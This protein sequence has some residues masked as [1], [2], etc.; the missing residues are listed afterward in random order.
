MRSRRSQTSHRAIQRAQAGASREASLE[1]LSGT[2]LEEPEEKMNLL[3]KYAQVRAGPAKA[4][5]ESDT[6]AQKTAFISAARLKAASI[7]VLSAL[8]ARRVSSNKSFVIFSIICAL[9]V[10]IAIL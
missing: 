3:S 5:A 10:G 2:H 9:Q 8:D 1:S 7:H 6:V 4:S